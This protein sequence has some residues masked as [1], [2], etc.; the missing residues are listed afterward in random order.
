VN[1]FITKPASFSGLL[2]V[3]KNLGRYWLETVALP[4]DGTRND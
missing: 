1:S 2:E 3:V 4:T